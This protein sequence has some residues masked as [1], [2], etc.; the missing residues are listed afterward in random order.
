[1]PRLTPSQALDKLAEWINANPSEVSVETLIQQPGN[2]AARRTLQR[3][4]ALLAA[5]QRIGVRG[6]GRATRYHRLPWPS[7]SVQPSPATAPATAVKAP[8][9]WRRFKIEPPC[10]L[11][12]EPGLMANL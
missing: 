10:R 4:L 6:E 12:F 1:M 3:R 5:Q 7:A 11:N 2:T 9:C 8:S